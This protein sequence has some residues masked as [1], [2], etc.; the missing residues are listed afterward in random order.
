MAS[1]DEKDPEEEV[2]PWQKAESTFIGYVIYR[3]E[4]T[5]MTSA[6]NNPCSKQYSEFYDP[7]AEASKKSMKCLHRNGGDRSLCTDYF[8]SVSFIAGSSGKS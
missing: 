6:F 1:K 5:L 8:Q 2:T 7:C 4:Q 3:K